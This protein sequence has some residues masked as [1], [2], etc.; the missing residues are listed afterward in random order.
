MTDA[1]ARLGIEDTGLLN[2]MAA[3]DDY[4]NELFAR[5]KAF[6]SDIDRRDSEIDELR[7]LLE[8]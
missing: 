4:V 5:L 3:I 6:Q 2:D 8:L 1:I 7:L